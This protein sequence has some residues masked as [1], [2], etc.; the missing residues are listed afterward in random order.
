MAYK[1][2]NRGDT[3]DIKEYED[4]PYEGKYTGC[5]EVRTPL[6]Q[7]LIYKFESEKGTTFSIWGFTILDS[8]MENVSRGDLCRITYKG[9]SPEKNKYGKHTH[10]CTVDVDD[11]ESDASD[12]DAPIVDESGAPF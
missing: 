5:K 1:P 8:Y 4:V 2:V 12:D 7:S 10:L 11:G 3:L 9:Q 6:G